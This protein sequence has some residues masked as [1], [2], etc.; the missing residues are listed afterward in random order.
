MVG[1]EGGLRRKSMAMRSKIVDDM[2]GRLAAAG[3]ISHRTGSG[4]GG[5]ARFAG[6]EVGVGEWPPL[7]LLR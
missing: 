6:T 7:R 1:G 3:H 2:V 4:G 5:D